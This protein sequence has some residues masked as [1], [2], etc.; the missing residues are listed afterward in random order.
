[1]GSGKRSY[2]QLTLAVREEISRGLAAGLKQGII[3]RKVGFSTCAI[4]RE[5]RRHSVADIGYRAHWAQARADDAAG[6]KGRHRKLD[7]WY[8]R[9]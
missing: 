6:R 8:W 4:G 2:T 7:G 5:I 3:A 1:M 9:D